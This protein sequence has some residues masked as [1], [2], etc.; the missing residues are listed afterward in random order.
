MGR[1]RTGPWRRK[2]NGCWYTTE[3]KSKKYV[4]LAEANESYEIALEKY[5]AH[6]AATKRVE[7]G[8]T[9]TVAELIDEFLEWC[10]HDRA[11]KTYRWYRDFLVRFHSRVG[12]S[13]LVANLKPY[14]VERWVQSDYAGKSANYRRGAIRSVQRLMSWSVKQGYILTNPIQGMEKPRQEAREVVVTEDQERDILAATSPEF[15]DY[16]RFAIFTGARPQETRIIKAKHY[17][18][19]PKPRLILK[20]R[21]SK[22]KVY[23]RVITLNPQSQEIVERLIAKHPTGAIFRDSHGKPWTPNSVRV[24]FRRLREKLK[25]PEG[26]HATSLRHTFATRAA[27]NGV[28]I[29]SLSELLGHRSIE[30][31]VR[32]YAHLAKNHDHLADAAAR[33]IGGENHSS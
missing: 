9:V 25:L 2:S 24:R 30:T 5:H 16:I 4:K 17:H 14:H 32:N 7:P 27:L 3:P 29:A 6:H 26:I 18:A 22:G 28:D 20:R 15:Q 8:P 19:T 33:A 11:P 13:L 21:D 31:T 1:K 12:S 23:H 10:Q